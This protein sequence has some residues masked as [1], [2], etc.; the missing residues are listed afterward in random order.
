MSRKITPGLRMTW[1][2]SF[3]I[4]TALGCHDAPKNAVSDTP[5]SGTIHISADESFKPV[6]E[7]EIRVYEATFPGT[8]ILASYKSEADCFRDLYSDSMNRMVIV[9]RGLTGKEARFYND[10]LGFSPV[11]DRIASDAITLVVNKA[12]N[13]T[14]FTMDRLQKLLTGKLGGQHPVVF[15]GLNATSTVRFVIDSILKGEKFDTSLVKA[16]KNSTAVLNYVASNPNAIGLVG[17]SWIGNPEDTAQL[18]M[19]KKV[20]IGYVQCGL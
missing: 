20:K 13:V 10:S 19:L 7:E 18:N 17:I 5:A 16:E 15:D 11:S 2:I 12:N 3:A 1:F 4:L 9:T 14:L 8:K 6:I